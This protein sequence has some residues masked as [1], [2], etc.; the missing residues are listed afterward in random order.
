MTIDILMQ[1]G[2]AVFGLI[3]IT[4]MAI[5]RPPWLW[6]GCVVG[7]VSEVFWFWAATHPMQPGILAL[8]TVYTVIFFLGAIGHR[9]H[10]SRK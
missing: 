9:P 4:F 3:A 6:L 5:G 1:L 7:L 8:A 2:L 10:R